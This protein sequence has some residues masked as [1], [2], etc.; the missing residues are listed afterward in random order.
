MKNTRALKNL[1]ITDR[2]CDAV[3]P[4]IG[5]IAYVND[6]RAEKIVTTTFECS[7]FGPNSGSIYKIGWVCTKISILYINQFISYLIKKE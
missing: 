4:G 5:D 1:M 6:L 2:G 3:S 7:V